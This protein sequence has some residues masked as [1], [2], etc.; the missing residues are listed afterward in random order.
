MNPGPV[1]LLAPFPAGKPTVSPTSG[2]AALMTFD[3][4]HCSLLFGWN[5]P[6]VAN[7]AKSPTS[8]EQQA[9]SQ[10]PGVTQRTSLI[11]ASLIKA[12]TE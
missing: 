11:K 7:P 2:F 1:D 10:V 9:V 3:R 12:I 6:G 8:C 4:F 5:W